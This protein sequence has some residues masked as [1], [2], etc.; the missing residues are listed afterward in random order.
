[1]THHF[2]RSV[3]REYDVRGII[4][5]TLSLAD[6]AALGRAFGTMVVRAGGSR[7]VVGRDGR[8]SSPAM[9][10]TLIEGLMSTGLEVLDIGLG[11]TPMTYFSV[12][13]LD[14]DGGVMVTGSHNPPNYNGFK[15]MLGKKAFYGAQIQELGKIAKAGD[16]VEGEGKRANIAM[17]ARYVERLLE[18]FEGKA[19]NV[20]WDPGN[21]A[22]GAV[23]A[24]LIKRL[25]G[26]H[27]L[28]N[29][30]IDGTFPNHHPDP[31]EEKNLVQLKEVVAEHGLDLGIAF[32][33]DGDRIGAVDAQGRVVWG[34]QLLA[35]LARDV[36]ADMPGS[37]IIADVKASQGLFDEIARLGGK[38]MMWKTGHSLIKSKMAEEKAPLAGE[39]SGHI[40]FSHKFYGFDDAIYAAIRLLNAVSNHG[41]SLGDLR[42]AL[43]QMVNTPELR[44][45]CDEDKKFAIVEKVVE[46]LRAQGADFSD[47]DGARVNTPDGWWLLRASNTQAVLV[48]RAEGKDEAALARLKSQLVEILTKCGVEAP[49]GL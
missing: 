6:A 11:P 47:I 40:F 26:R 17:Q 41:G 10:D 33:G 35:I 4:D 36:L 14:A 45:E 28:I 27:V 49:D 44:F 12:F 31:T 24:N 18:D 48:A 8:V 2:H 3:L 38:P 43:P 15:M 19:L 1:M 42:D 21:G 29:S 30:D 16:V 22:S 46:E 37:T 9:A 7:V 13:E 25:P 23:V 32:D 20:A 39:M 5:E 34:D